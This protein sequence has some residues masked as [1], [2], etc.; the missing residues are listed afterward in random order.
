MLIAIDLSSVLVVFSKQGNRRYRTS[1]AV[2]NRTLNSIFFLNLSPINAKSTL[3]SDVNASI[4][5]L[6]ISPPTFTVTVVT[7]TSVSVILTIR[8][9]RLIS[10]F[11][12]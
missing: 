10:P 1:P 4:Y 12:F 6:F 11:F 2:C 3:L 8:P 5:R 7:A 9:N